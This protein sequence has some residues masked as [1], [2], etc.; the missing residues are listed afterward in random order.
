[1][2]T[3]QRV[4]IEMPATLINS[5]AGKKANKMPVAAYARVSTDREEQ[6]D[7]FERQV[8]HYTQLIQQQESWEFVEVYAD[9]GISGTKAEKRP[10][11][12]RMIE[13]CRQGKIKRILVKSISR[14]ARNTI[15]ALVYIRELR[16]L[17]VGITFETENIDTLT[18]G[19]EVL[20][21][22]L[23]AIAEEESRSISKNVRWAFQRKFKQG[24]VMINTGI[25]LG[26]K[27]VG[28]DENGNSVYEIVEEEAEIVRRIYREYVMG[29]SITG[30]CRDLENDGITTK[31]GSTKWRPST[32]KKMLMNEK[33]TGN[34]ILGKTYK[35]DVMSKKR[36]IN[37]GEAAK[38]YI[39]NSHPAIIPQSTYDRVQ[40][41]IQ[42][43]NQPTGLQVGTT[44]YCSKY[45]YS[46]ILVCGNCFSRLRR[47]VR[48]YG[49]GKKV[50]S[51]ACPELIKEGRSKCD[52]HHVR[53]DVLDKTYNAAFEEMIGAIDEIVAE[54]EET[55]D[56]EAEKETKI[57]TE[58][59]ETEILEIQ[60]RIMAIH[61]QY[62]KKKISETE[63]Y[64][65]IESGT[66]ELRDA[67]KRREQ[68]VGEATKQAEVRLRLKT[69][70]SVCD[71]GGITAID[72]NMVRAIT[73]YIVVNDDGIEIHLK[74]GAV[75][76]KEYVK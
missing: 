75:I 8:E 28:K 6:E 42:T 70:T 16:D 44:R 38:Y 74:C 5:G 39:K 67:E 43:R 9:P 51:W 57:Q 21:T 30:I 3:A 54:I 12:M 10:N 29:K 25:M 73:E 24:D 41:L 7:S 61:K 33:Y 14:F 48:K 53:E 27:K 35:P 22:I 56:T 66:K 37:N 64:E 69:I 59:I 15:D 4:V 76:T 20:L 40:Q 19:G 49:T 52:S 46:G 71:A 26:Y 47:H 58:K 55:I 17:G 68:L 65:Q 63:Y 23:A 45:R 60:K 72:D 36:L 34:A 62:S 11:F 2:Q 50:A 32:V 1:M 13:D 31:L 18:Q